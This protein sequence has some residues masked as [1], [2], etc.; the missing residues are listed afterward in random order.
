MPKTQPVSNF[1]KL[2]QR[3][4]KHVKTFL[5]AEKKRDDCFLSIEK[6]RDDNSFYYLALRNGMGNVLL[7]ARFF[8]QESELKVLEPQENKKAIPNKVS[9]KVHVLNDSNQQFDLDELINIKFLSDID[10]QTFL[11]RFESLD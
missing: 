6:K 5:V 4:V 3:K 10:L 9:M 11:A 2:F 7:S 8:K 1:E